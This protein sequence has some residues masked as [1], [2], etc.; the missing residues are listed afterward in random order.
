[1]KTN[2]IVNYLL[3]RNK[4]IKKAKKEAI[5]FEKNYINNKNY[6]GTKNQDKVIIE[7]FFPDKYNGFFVE[8][9]A[10]TGAKK[11]NTY[12]L[13][14]VFKWK[15]IC[16]EPNTQYFK[17]LKNLRNCICLNEC[18]DKDNENIIFLNYK[19]T[20]GIVGLDTDNKFEALLN[21]ILDGGTLSVKPTKT[22]SQILEIY[23]APKIIDYLSLDVEGAEDRIL[24]DFPFDK[25]KFKIMTIEEPSKVLINY[26]ENNGYKM[27]RKL[28]SVKQNS[29]TWDGLF[30]LNEA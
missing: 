21:K 6:I 13:E 28:F 17:V 30:K 14:K 24:L 26:I 20:G 5:S 1:M 10:Y 3:N 29:E 27:I 8:L 15:G 23:K 19:T 18:I 4:I 22:L 2:R 7:E 16:I 25:Y 9:G 12:L 11:S